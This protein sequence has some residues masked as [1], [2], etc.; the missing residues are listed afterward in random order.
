VNTETYEKLFIRLLFTNDEARAKIY[1]FLVPTIFESFEHQQIIQDF[2]K[3]KQ[4]RD[5]YPTFSELQLLCKNSEVHKALKDVMDVDTSEYDDEFVLDVSEDF[6]KGQL[7]WANIVKGKELLTNNEV[8]EKGPELLDNL[9]DVLAFSYD[10]EIGLDFLN[11]S[12]RIYENLTSVDNVVPTGIDNLDRLIKGGL[13]EKSLT[14]LMAE[15]NMGKTLIQCGLAVNC[16]LQNKN[17]LYVTLEMSEDKISERILANLIDVDINELPMMKKENFMNKMEKLSTTMKSNFIIKEFPTKSANTNRIRNLLKELEIKKKFVPDIVFVDYMGI[18]TT[19]QKF[20]SGSNSNTELKTISE[21]LR[22][23]AVET[24]VPFIS[25]V[26][27]NR[28]GFAS[29]EIDL[30]DIADSIGTTATADV[31]IGITQTDELRASGLYNFIILKNRYGINKMRTPVGVDY[32]KM[33]VFNVEDDEGSS[34][35]PES[36]RTVDD[37]A[38]MLNHSGSRR[39]RNVSDIE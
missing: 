34:P 31:I 21:E 35:T 20:A 6:I 1:P 5:K 24:G 4:D 22:G 27:T 33:R 17:V 36:T 28:G 23:L 39:R 12:E 8:S 30:T 38:V 7:F 14:L 15:T 16:L 10:T 11:S 37:A 25:A 19:N 26:Q 29:S 3:F 18:M 13:H 2:M 9:R 32:P